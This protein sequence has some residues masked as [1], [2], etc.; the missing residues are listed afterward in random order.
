MGRLG[1][2]FVPA[3][4]LMAAL[5]G[6]PRVVAGD[7]RVQVLPSSSVMEIET[8]IGVPKWRLLPHLFSEKTVNVTCPGITVRLLLHVLLPGCHQCHQR[9]QRRRVRTSQH[10]TQTSQFELH[11][12]IQ[13]QDFSVYVAEDPEKLVERVQQQ[14][15]AWCG[16]QSLLSWDSHTCATRVSPF[17]DTAVAVVHSPKHGERMTIHCTCFLHMPHVRVDACFGQAVLHANGPPSRRRFVAA[18][19]ILQSPEA[20]PSYSQQEVSGGFWLHV[21]RC[22]DKGT[23]WTSVHAERDP[24]SSCV[25]ACAGT[26]S[27]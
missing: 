27:Y 20:P 8:F 9:H 11:T 7:R 24:P 2:V 6:M 21:P 19:I 1:T 10:T 23:R 13:L 3:L 17:A 4:A 16:L 25:H 15:G 14:R 22:S 12:S 26:M 5:S 18:A